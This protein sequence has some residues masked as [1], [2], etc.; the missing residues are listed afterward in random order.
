MR[1][2]SARAGAGDGCLEGAP[3]DRSCARREARGRMG[4]SRCARGRGLIASNACSGP[5][6]L[7]LGALLVLGP[8]LGDSLVGFF[9]GVLCTG[10]VALPTVSGAGCSGELSRSECPNGAPHTSPGLNPGYGVPTVRSEG[11]PH[12]LVLPPVLRWP[13]AG[14]GAE[15][16]CLDE[17]PRDRSCARRERWDRLSYRAAA[18]GGSGCRRSNARSGPVPLPLGGSVVGLALGV[19]RGWELRGISPALAGKLGGGWGFRAVREGF[20]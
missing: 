9:V 11:T 19:S 3:R 18:R 13:S 16:H 20:W 15:D 12:T 17:A 7:P 5:V 10:E 8:D 2:R 4:L 1:W 6:P 14:A